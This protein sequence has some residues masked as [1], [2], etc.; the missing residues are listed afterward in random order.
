LLENLNGGRAL[1]ETILYFIGILFKFKKIGLKNIVF[2]Y[3]TS[4]LLVQVIKNLGGTS[5]YCWA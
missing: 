1:I 3:V 5:S 2:K 4:A